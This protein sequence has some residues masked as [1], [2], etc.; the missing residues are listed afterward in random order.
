LT[1]REFSMAILKVVLLSIVIMSLVFLGLAIQTLMKKKGKFPNTHIGSNK[2]MK[3]NGVT[4]AQTF[5]KIEQAKA[6]K[7]LRFKE[8]VDNN[9]DS[10]YFC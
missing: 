4:C 2:Y 5:D 9:A 1:E 8:F 7:D 10:K 6:R 3:Q